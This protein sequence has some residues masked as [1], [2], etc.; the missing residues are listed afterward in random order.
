[1][2]L[3]IF[4]HVGSGG[5]LLC[6]GGVCKATGGQD[7][8]G[9][10]SPSTISTVVNLE[11]GMFAYKATVA[12]DMH[13]ADHSCMA[14]RRPVVAGLILPL[15]VGLSLLAATLPQGSSKFRVFTTLPRCLACFGIVDAL[16]VAGYG[17]RRLPT[18]EGFS[19]ILCSLFGCV[20]MCITTVVLCTRVG[21]CTSPRRR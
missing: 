9:G 8:S 7:F 10:L 21:A 16:F 20:P 2:H 13:A 5:R 15:Y 1:M 18:M 6:V 19:S 12:Y 14:T 3:L 4:S 17:A 11:L